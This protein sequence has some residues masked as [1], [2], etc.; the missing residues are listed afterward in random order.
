MQTW[1][2]EAIFYQVYPKSFKDSNADGIGDLR[3]IIEKLDYLQD[4]G[5]DIIW[6]SPFFQ[7]PMVDN[8]YDI[9]DYYKVDPIFGTN[10]D[11]DDLIKAA[12]RRNIKIIFD[13]VVNHFSSEHEW[14]KKAI[15]DPNSE[16]RDYFIIKKKKEITNCLLI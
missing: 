1:W 4:L 13:L 14:F 8:G 15:S 12:K 11:L 7:S 9:S 5:I 3:G 16:E 6:V 2:K 10:E